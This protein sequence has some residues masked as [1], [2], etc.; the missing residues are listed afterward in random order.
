[1]SKRMSEMLAEK[2]EEALEG[3]LSEDDSKDEIMQGI[4][5]NVDF[6]DLV[7]ELFN[8]NDEVKEVLKKKVEVLLLKEIDAIENLEDFY[9]DEDNMH[10]DIR[11]GADVSEIVKEILKSDMDLR[12]KVKSIIKSLVEDQIKNMDDDDIPGWEDLLELAGFNDLIN[13]LIKE[14]LKHDDIRKSLTDKLK[15][16]L[17][18]YIEDNVSDCD[19]PENIIELL[20]ISSRVETLLKDRVFR[21]KISE[22]IQQKLQDVI[23]GFITGEEGDLDLEGKVRDHPEIKRLVERQADELLRDPL[24]VDKLKETLKSKLHDDSSKLR[25]ELIDM[26]FEVMAKTMAERLFL[27]P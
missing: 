22:K 11:E 4:R 27:K 12:K 17:E 5:D 26:M 20:E 9:D 13:D 21:E 6:K 18:S 25:S 10:S 2:I 7:S 16:E 24:F 8:E 3:V 14:V 23:S 19:L 1:M 15:A